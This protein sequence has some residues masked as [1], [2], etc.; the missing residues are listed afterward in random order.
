MREAWFYEEMECLQGVAIPRYY[1]CFKLSLE[2]GCRVHPWNDTQCYSSDTDPDYCAD[3]VQYP[4]EALVESGVSPHPLLEELI[5]ETNSV[6]VTILERLSPELRP[7][8]DHPLHVQSALYHFKL[9][10]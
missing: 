7:G 4:E 9:S 10:L 8:V 2:K 5:L 1:G 3:R 6:Y